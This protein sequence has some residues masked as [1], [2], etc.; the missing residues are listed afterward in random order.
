MPIK[1]ASNSVILKVS[2]T[3]GR[4]FNQLE[5]IVDPLNHITCRSVIK[6]TNNFIQ[7]TDHSFLTTGKILFRTG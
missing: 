2:K 5:L 1:Q 7:P 6:A 3:I 4:A